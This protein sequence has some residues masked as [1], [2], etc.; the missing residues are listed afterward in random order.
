MQ[1]FGDSKLD[2]Q[3]YCVQV[4]SEVVGGQDCA[5]AHQPAVDAVSGP[6]ATPPAFTSPL[7]I[8]PPPRSSAS[9]VV[10]LADLLVLTGMLV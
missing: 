4:V 2:Q 1:N 9:E 5:D 3:A 8:L 10:R 7:A 6:E